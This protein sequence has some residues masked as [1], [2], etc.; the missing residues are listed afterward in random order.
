VRA[1]VA[2]GSNLGSRR[3]HLDGA[4]AALTRAR[5]VRVVRSSGWVETEPQGGPVG[6]GRYLNGV[7]ELETT[8]G[9]R[10]LLDL[11]LAIE[12]EAGRVR[13]ER[14]G[15][16]TLDLDLLFFGDAAIDEPD[17]IVPHPRLEEREFVLEPLAQLEPGRVLPRSR[18]TVRERLAELRAGARIPT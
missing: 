10:E 18:V 11:L 7:V 8:L 2:L 4:V 6:Q 13:G 3:A 1:W 15:P 14:N 16:R 17:L 9:A 12:R 5:G